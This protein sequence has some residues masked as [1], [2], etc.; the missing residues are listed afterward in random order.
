MRNYVGYLTLII[1]LICCLVLEGPLEGKLCAIGLTLVAGA[2]KARKDGGVDGRYKVVWLALL[3]GI[4]FLA[5]AFLVSYI[6]NH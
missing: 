4:G 3:L 1:I 5:A 2:Y 6:K